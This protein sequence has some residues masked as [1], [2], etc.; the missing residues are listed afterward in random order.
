MAMIKTSSCGLV[1]NNGNFGWQNFDC[2]QREKK[3]VN[4]L[5]LWYCLDLFSSALIVYRYQRD[6][7]KRRFLHEP[8]IYHGRNSHK[9]YTHKVSLYH[10][11][12]NSLL[13]IQLNIFVSN[14]FTRK[15]DLFDHYSDESP[16]QQGH[17]SGCLQK[18][19]EEMTSPT[20]IMLVLMT[21]LII[22][23]YDHRLFQVL[24]A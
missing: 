11:A 20:N 21:G 5:C 3:Q 22:V 9:K 18:W 15:Y 24:G 2:G 14:K 23:G 16:N 12:K 19:E 13:C 7:K 8:P 4:K 6:N 10:D 1:G 17:L